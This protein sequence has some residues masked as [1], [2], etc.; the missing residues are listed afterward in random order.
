VCRLEIPSSRD[1]AAKAKKGQQ[2]GLS[3]NDRLRSEAQLEVSRQREVLQRYVREQ[4][5]LDYVAL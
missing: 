4:I 3:F 2:R 1:Q 5:S